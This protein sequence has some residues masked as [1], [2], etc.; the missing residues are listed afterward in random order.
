MVHATGTRLLAAL[1]FLLTFIPPFIH[2]PIIG[3]VLLRQ[4]KKKERE[5]KRELDAI[6]S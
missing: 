4:A 2:G 3:F 5:R 6:E 1:A